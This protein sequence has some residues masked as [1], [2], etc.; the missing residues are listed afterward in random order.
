MV[1][2][3][4]ADLSKEQLEGK[5]VFVR[6]DLNVPQ[7]GGSRVGVVGGFSAWLSTQAMCN[8]SCAACKLV[9]DGTLCMGATN[10]TVLLSLPSHVPLLHLQCRT[11]RQ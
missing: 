7:V 10:T 9:Q 1:K 8:H 5:V 2:K 3:N 11:R 4:V 6:A